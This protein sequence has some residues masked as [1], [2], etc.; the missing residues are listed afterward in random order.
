M[1]DMEN[2]PPVLNQETESQIAKFERL[3]SKCEI[4][5]AALRKRKAA[6]DQVLADLEKEKDG[7]ASSS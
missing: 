2:G 4:L 5:L 1:A 7:P 3:I 6:L